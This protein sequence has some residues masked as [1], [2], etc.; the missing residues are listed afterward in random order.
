MSDFTEMDAAL[1]QID[2]VGDYCQ[3]FMD[4][5]DKALEVMDEITKYGITQDNYDTLKELY[6]DL[7]ECELNLS[8][9]PIRLTSDKIGTEAAGGLSTLAIGALLTAFAAIIGWILSKIF[10]GSS[11]GGGGGGGGISS[12]TVLDKTGWGFQTKQIIEYHNAMMANADA[13][14]KK[15]H[16][17]QIFKVKAASVLLTQIADGVL[18]DQINEVARLQAILLEMVKNGSTPEETLKVINGDFHSS[19]NKL[20]EAEAFVPDGIKKTLII[21]KYAVIGSARVHLK[22]VATDVNVKLLQLYDQYKGPV[23]DEAQMSEKATNDIESEC[24]KLQ[25]SLASNSNMLASKGADENLDSESL[26]SISMAV[27]ILMNYTRTS[28][29]KRI[30][31]ATKASQHLCDM[32]QAGCLAGL[33]IVIGLDKENMAKIESETGFTAAE[34]KSLNGEIKKDGRSNLKG[35][36]AAL[37][38]AKEVFQALDKVITLSDTDK[39]RLAK[40]LLPNT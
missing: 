26:G 13:K 19:Y 6:P 35:R 15:K 21:P 25:T 8:A 31:T 17:A 32:Y 23:P 40:V 18:A 9:F 33:A 36:I 5:L 4:A 37:L 10:G 30:V 20:I 14:G 12:V 16:T 24:K 29:L 7:S 27:Q 28:I 39:E 11:S 22:V 3:P 38:K 34:I 2:A 1:D